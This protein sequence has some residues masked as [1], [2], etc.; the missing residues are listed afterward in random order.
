[1]KNQIQLGKYQ[2]TT[3][4]YTKIQPEQ[5]LTNVLHTLM[6]S[7]KQGILDVYVKWKNSLTLKTIDHY[8]IGKL[9]SQLDKDTIECVY[10][11][12]PFEKDDYQPAFDFSGPADKSMYY[13]YNEL[14]NQKSSMVTFTQMSI[15]QDLIER[16][17]DD[18]QMNV[19]VITK[20]ERELMDSLEECTCI[21]MRVHTKDHILD[22]IN[23]ILYVLSAD[24]D[25]VNKQPDP[26]KS[27]MIEDIRPHVLEDE[28]FMENAGPVDKSIYALSLHES[29]KIQGHSIYV[30]RVPGGWIYELYDTDTTTMNSVFVPFNNEFQ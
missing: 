28:K 4:I 10:Y 24:M 7:H 15:D 5:L 25:V 29:T 11:N 19:W 30:T 3:K 21:P 9:E 20:F 17:Y 13:N 26:K 27:D 23:S 6:H 18:M 22:N 14:K 2:A 1:M 8:S 16:L 12:L